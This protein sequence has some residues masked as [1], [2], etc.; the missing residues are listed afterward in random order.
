MLL[1]VAEAVVLLGFKVMMGRMRMG[2]VEMGKMWMGRMGWKNQ[3][4]KDGDE[5]NRGGGKGGDNV[6]DGDWEAVAHQ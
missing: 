6:E 4:C 1:R 2:R 3:G 5:E